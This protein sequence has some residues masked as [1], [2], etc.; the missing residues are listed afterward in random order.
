MKWDRR[1]S[2][3]KLED[4]LISL[5]NKKFNSNLIDS[6][7]FS[8]LLCFSKGSNYQTCLNHGRPFIYITVVPLPESKEIQGSNLPKVKGLGL[9]PKKVVRD[10]KKYNSI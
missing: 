8:N 3:N 5:P 6:A 2:S 4:M 10:P 7:N 9:L 1:T